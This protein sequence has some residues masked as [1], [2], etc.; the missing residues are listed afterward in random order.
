VIRIGPFER[1]FERDL[2]EICWQTGFMGESLEG[3]GRFEDRR[4]FAL[5]FVLSFSR[6][7]P[8]SCFVAVDEKEGAPESARAVGYIVGSA[9][10][11][12]Q[13]RYFSRSFAPRIAARLFLYD[14]WRHPESFRQVMRF[15]RA[16]RKGK[17]DAPR[18][19]APA[20]GA[21]V[22]SADYPACLHTNILPAYQGRGLGTRLMTT[23]LDA[24]RARGI[25]GVYL[26]T[27]DR[28]L[29]ALPFYKKMGF[30]LLREEPGEFWLNAPAQSLTFVQR[31]Q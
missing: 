24:L 22:P 15:L 21:S 19:I 28:N 9:D 12:A 27:S 14:S 6:F 4:L 18:T 20:P 1:R 5:I 25:P 11:A 26:E 2:V 23:Y 7:E 31:L 10:A 13:A 3:L 30:A 16:S 8:S 29:K 17:A